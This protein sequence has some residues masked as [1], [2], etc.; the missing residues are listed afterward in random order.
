[1]ITT[2]LIVTL[3][4]DRLKQRSYAGFKFTYETI[5][6]CTHGGSYQGRIR[7]VYTPCTPDASR[8]VH[9][10]PDR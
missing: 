1:M 3:F 6:T 2:F 8:S 7:Q 4:V 5:P 9:A 10:L